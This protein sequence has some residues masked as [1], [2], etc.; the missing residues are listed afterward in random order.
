MPLNVITLP[1]TLPLHLTTKKAA[2]QQI[3][4]N[5]NKVK[6]KMCVS[7][8]V[9]HCVISNIKMCCVYLHISYFSRSLV[10]RNILSVWNHLFF[11]TFLSHV[12]SHPHPRVIF[13]PICLFWPL[14][15]PFCGNILLCENITRFYFLILHKIL[16]KMQVERLLSGKIARFLWLVFSWFFR[17]QRREKSLG[18]ERQKNL[19]FEGLDNSILIKWTRKFIV[20]RFTRSWRGN[21]GFLP[22]ARLFKPIF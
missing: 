20:E 3:F 10:K 7:Q 15:I 12:D 4:K 22:G 21:F 6:L 1:W 17:I 5:L 9:S 8:C 11:T 13:H 16:K 18:R 2:L 14:S 19:R